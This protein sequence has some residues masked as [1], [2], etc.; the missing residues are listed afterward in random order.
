MP[1]QIPKEY[2]ILTLLACSRALHRQIGAV[3]SRGS[4]HDDG[5]FVLPSGDVTDLMRLIAEIG[6]KLKDINIHNLTD[7]D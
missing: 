2:R 5:T 3:L 4:H 1:R 7:R 6:T